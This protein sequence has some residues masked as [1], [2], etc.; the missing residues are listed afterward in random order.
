V[1]DIQAWL[2]GAPVRVLPGLKGVRSTGSGSH[3]E[4][5]ETRT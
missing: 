2:G 1:E 4:I 5:F 3:K